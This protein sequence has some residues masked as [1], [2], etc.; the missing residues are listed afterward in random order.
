[1]SKFR[2]LLT[3]A[4]AVGGLAVLA[5]G[6]SPSIAGAAFGPPG[7][8]T[9]PPFWQ[10]PAVGKSTS[11][12]FLIDVTDSGNVI[13]QDSSQEFYDLGGD[14]EMVAV[15]NDSST[16][17]ASLHIGVAESGDNLFGFEGDGLCTPGVGAVPSGCPFGPGG[18][19]EDPFDYYGPG[20]A[21]APGY[22]AD[23]GTVEFTPALQRGQYA[24][25]GLDSPFETSKVV[26]PVGG[27]DYLTTAL[28]GGSPEN[29]PQISAPAPTNITDQ[30]TL[31]GPHHEGAVGTIAYKVYSDPACKQLVSGG[32]ATPASA[33]VT[34]GLIPSSKP[35]GVGLPT[36]AN[37][38]WQATFTSTGSTTPSDPSYNTNAVTACGAEAMAFG[39]P[40][41]RP[42]IGVS[43]TLAGGGHSGP[44]ITVLPATSVTDTAAI[45]GTNANTATGVV[46]YT[47]FAD[48][49]CTQQIRAFAVGT[50]T[51][52][53]A[54]GSAGASGALSLPLGTY[55]F[56]ATYSG[57]ESHAPA[58]S[59]C[60]GEVLTVANPVPP[61]PP[62]PNSLFTPVGNPQFNSKTGQIVVTAQF[63]APGTATTTGIVQ[64]GATLARVREA[65]AEA[66]RHRSARCR[67]G[68][69]KKGHRCV[70]NAPVVFGTTILAIPAPGTYS[71][72]I[73][74]GAKALKALK[75]GKKLNVVTSTTFQNRA[76][77]QPVTRIGDVQVKLKL[78]KHG[79]RHR[80]H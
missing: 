10:C 35:V 1:M 64:Q 73:N 11:C 3:L 54:G 77:G 51:R 50:D 74:P 76:G 39:T 59:T 53:V 55:Y 80:R 72:V 14:D 63:P 5:A 34:G 60:G 66:A 12:A 61:P 31:V 26:I 30:A 49:G 23:D 22:S 79:H 70:N 4:L 58:Q 18:S 7:G 41:P 56:R 40:P 44:S 68:F 33:T 37:Y 65:L 24:Y 16:P 62:K 36:D 42:Q 25:F 57:D 6:L 32:D 43:T 46:T 9:S 71:I 52:Q 29:E 8:P 28:A 17:L 15:Q 13:Y 2:S 45:T 47:V 69:V 21:F 27:N 19:N 78:K 67:H 75:A 38:Y 20:M 48:A